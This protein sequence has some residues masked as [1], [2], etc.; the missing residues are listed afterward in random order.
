LRLHKHQADAIITARSAENYVLTTG[1]GSGK[2][3]A[4]IIPT[5]DHV[6]RPRPM[7]ASL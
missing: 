2:S 6:L 4:Y 5:M 1:T 7:P 3:L